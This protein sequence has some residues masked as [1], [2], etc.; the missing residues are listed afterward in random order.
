VAFVLS[1][2]SR[3]GCTE[4][5]TRACLRRLPGGAEGFELWTSELTSGIFSRRALRFWRFVIPVVVRAGNAAKSIDSTEYDKST[6]GTLSYPRSARSSRRAAAMPAAPAPIITTST[7]AAICCM[8][9]GWLSCVVLSFPQAA[10]AA[11]GLNFTKWEFSVR[12]HIGQ[13]KI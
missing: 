8:L 2:F 11:A 10:A 12:T 9:S 4:K 1:R 13:P 5:G 7:S 6:V 3:E